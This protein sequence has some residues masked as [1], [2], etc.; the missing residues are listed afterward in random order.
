VHLQPSSAPQ[1]LHTLTKDVSQGGLRCLT[2]K[3]VPVGSE[4]RLEVL[5]AGSPIAMHIGGH[6]R[7]FREVPYSE[8]FEV[9]V[10]FEPV[11]P[12]TERRLSTYLE[13]LAQLQS[14]V[15]I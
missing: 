5:L 1:G 14:P 4:V 9:G 3:P 15:V 13:R 6:T 11:D 12:E 10:A 2:P 8:M 7:W